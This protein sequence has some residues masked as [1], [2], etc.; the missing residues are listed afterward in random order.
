MNIQYF[1]LLWCCLR[2]VSPSHTFSRPNYGT[3]DVPVTNLVV[4]PYVQCKTNNIFN[5]FIGSL[6]SRSSETI[7]S[8]VY[9]FQQHL[10]F[11]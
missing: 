2:T 9:S 8:L 3:Y 6:N 4:V 11:R 7:S 10:R 1:T 5:L